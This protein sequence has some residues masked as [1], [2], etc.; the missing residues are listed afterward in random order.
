MLGNFN[1][2]KTS[3][4]VMSPE[5]GCSQQGRIYRNFWNL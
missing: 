1:A 3:M 4:D 5:M 2:N